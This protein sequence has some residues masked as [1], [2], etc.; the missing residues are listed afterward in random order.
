M[1]MKKMDKKD[2]EK[3]NNESDENLV[4]VD[5]EPGVDVFADLLGFGDGSENV[6]V[7]IHRTEPEFYG[8]KNITGFLGC[9]VQGDS[10]ETLQ[11][12][13]G[14]GRYRIQ[15]FVNNRINKTGYIRIS[16]LPRMPVPED[17]PDR[18]IAD[19]SSGAN[20]SDGALYKGIPLS[21]SNA[22]FLAMVERI[23]LLKNVFPEKA[24]INDTLLKV[25]LARGSDGNNLDSLLSQT[26]KLGRLVEQFGG[27]N[28]G[29]GGSS[30]IDLGIKA[31]DGV[32]KYIQSAGDMQRTKIMSEIRKP[33][34]VGAGPGL[35]TDN[36]PEKEVEKMPENEQMTTKQIAEKAAGIIVLGFIQDP[37]QA[38]A[39]TVKLL[40]F[41]LPAFDEAG[42][43]GI[44]DNRNILYL[45]ARNSLVSEIE[46]DVEIG[47]EFD[48]YFNNIFNQF[49]GSTGENIQK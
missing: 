32:T 18:P 1:T 34:I 17:N 6:I 4:M 49:V 5:N 11:E 10:F 37:K 48:L 38:E 45:L 3:N 26:E 21:G 19:A 31:I 40:R 29:G 28:H 22:E 42:L 8:G 15:K 13:F 24:D 9:L 27:G 12:K 25:A 16:G 14:G 47:N 33:A 44:R 46:V 43:K 2:S 36:I 39:E 41:E 20:V 23:H 35:I 7:R 30:L